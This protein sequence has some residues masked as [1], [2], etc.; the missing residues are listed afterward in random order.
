M[1]VCVPATKIYGV[2]NRHKDVFFLLRFV[3]GTLVGHTCNLLG[4]YDIVHEHISSFPF[5]C[6]LAAID[7]IFQESLCGNYSACLI[8]YFT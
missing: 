8:G 4:R 1:F 7:R 5:K 3:V 6:T 2:M